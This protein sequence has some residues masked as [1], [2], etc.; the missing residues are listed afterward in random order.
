MK[1]KEKKLEIELP[2]IKERDKWKN[3]IFGEKN[4]PFIN[5]MLSIGQ[6][7][8]HK[9][10]KYMNFWVK[11]NEEKENFY[12]TDTIVNSHCCK[13]LYCLLSMLEDPLESDMCSVL[14]GL[15]K[16]LHRVRKRISGNLKKEVGDDQAT[17]DI[18]L[19]VLILEHIYDQKE[20]L[21]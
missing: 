10:I 7:G 17:P 1:K 21:Y 18:N 19:I 8:V 16:M 9:I 20:T 6:K 12:G 13:W 4:N 14:S 11:E 15:R 5:L 3:F 2:S